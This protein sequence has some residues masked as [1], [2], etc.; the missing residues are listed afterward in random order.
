MIY[1]KVCLDENNENVY[2]ELYVP[3][4]IYGR[5]KDSILVIPGGGYENI[6]SNREGEPVA[7][8]FTAKGF[9]AFVLHYSDLPDTWLSSQ[10]LQ[11]F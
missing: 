8:A 11:H 1:E 6:C 9:N 3:D 7:L 5:K 10:F 4:D 2:L